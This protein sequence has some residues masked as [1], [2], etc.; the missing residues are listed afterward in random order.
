MKIYIVIDLTEGNVNNVYYKGDS[1][2]EAQDK[3]NELEDYWVGKGIDP[4]IELETYTLPD[5][6]T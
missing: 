4:Q 2:M 6:L 5:D 1:L 3:I